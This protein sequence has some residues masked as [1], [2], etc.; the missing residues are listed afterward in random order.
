MPDTLSA[1]QDL[2]VTLSISSGFPFQGVRFW[3]QDTRAEAVFR[4][5]HGLGVRRL[6]LHQTLLEKAQSIGV[7]FHWH[8]TVSGI[9][10]DEALVGGRTIR[11]RW[12]IGADGVGSRVRRWCGINEQRH[13]AYRFASRMHYRVEPWSRH[14]EVYWGEGAQAYVTPVGA[15][16][17]CVVL[18]SRSPGVRL[19]SVPELFP[20]LAKR[21]DPVTCIGAERGAVTATR[22]LKSVYRGAVALVGDASGSV[23]AITG[24][25]LC[26]SFRQATALASAM[27]A[28]DLRRYQAAHRR[29]A[30]RP[31]WM[32]H[33]LL[34]LDRHPS[35]RR[36]T[37]STLAA[38]PE[39]FSR[40]LRVHI[41]AASSLEV[42]C[43]G[44]L[45][46]WRLVRA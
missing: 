11:A 23:D 28:G 40:L 34:L 16:A 44:T 41:G 20:A 21:L 18:V 45:L 12:I 4:E 30:R 35:L 15:E 27:E 46:S 9:C 8:T 39:V 25:G 29:L 33:L 10:N 14:V 13:G 26:L 38:H 32:A 43:A 1:L 42:A 31:T 22:R 19:S 5:G 6:V 36:R 17:V 7:R 24:D 3:E 37:V 2:G